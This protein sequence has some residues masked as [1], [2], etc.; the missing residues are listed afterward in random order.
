MSKQEDFKT[1][2]YRFYQMHSTKSKSFIVK[3]F[4][5]K[6][7]SRSTVYNILRRIE[8]NISV[9]PQYVS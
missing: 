6:G 1:Q 8:N 5:D 4:I 9:E 3:H 2:V 7:K